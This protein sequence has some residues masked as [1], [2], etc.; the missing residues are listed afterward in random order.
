MWIRELVNK[1]Q[2]NPIIRT[3]T[4]YFRHS[5]QPTSENRILSRIFGC[6]TNNNGARLGWLDSLILSFT[7][8]FNHNPSQELTINDCLR[9]APVW[10]DDDSPLHRLTFNWQ[11]TWFESKLGQSVGLSWCQA[12]IWGLRPDFCYCQTVACLFV[13]DALSDQRSGLPFTIA[14]G[15]RQRSRPWVRVPRD[16]WLYFAVSDSRLPQ[17]GGP[18]P[19]IYIPQ[20]QG[21]PVIPPGTGFPFRRLL[22][23]AGLRWRYSN[24]P[25]RGVVSQRS[26]M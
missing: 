24:Q 6:V 2:I 11:L 19:R 18:G 17:P 14:A 13:W 1:V 26:F 21:G 25:P 10:P 8:T 3:R 22:R 15:S 4:R 7:V 23:L 9:L 20:E 12:P 5:Y 16:S